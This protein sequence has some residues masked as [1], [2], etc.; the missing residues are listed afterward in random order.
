MRKLKNRKTA[1]KSA[2][3]WFSKFIRLRDSDSNG[4][5]Q[6]ITCGKVT[7]WKRAHAGHFMSRRFE[8]TR[9]DEKNVASQCVS[10]NTFGQGQQFK[11]GQWIDKTY[12]KGTAEKLEI[13]SKQLCKRKKFDY[14]VLSDTYKKKVKELAKDK[15]IEL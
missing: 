7:H 14:E 15:G 6:C 10:C 4:L 8:S 5:I 11:F 1:K 9:Y 12:G 3:R 13:K 2:D